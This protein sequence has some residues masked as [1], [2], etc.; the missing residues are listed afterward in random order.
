MNRF[1]IKDVEN[2]SGIKAHTWRIWEQRY[3]LALPQRKES[4][5]RFYDTE[6]LKQ[7][8]RISYLYHQQMK[9]S[10]IAKLEPEEMKRLALTPLLKDQENEYYAKELLEASLDFDE[11][12]FERNIS[13]ALHTFGLED[14]ILKVIYPY[15]ERIGML[16]LTDH[17]VPAQEHFT[18]NL[19]RQ[20]LL[21]AIDNLPA[22]AL[23]NEQQIALF[24]PEDE[25]HEIP[26]LFIYYLL[27]KK[28]CKVIYFGKHVSLEALQS[29]KGSKPLTHALFHLVTNLTNKNADEYV[30]QVADI[31]KDVKVIMSGTQV[32]AVTQTPDNFRLLHS[33]Q[34]IISFTDEFGEGATK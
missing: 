32:L 6:N 9:V 25:Q 24:T 14:T 21:V 4:K 11:E 3:K 22:V 23:G 8:L 26:L 7:V 28:G 34:E 17:V 29:Y 13:I 19:I 10:K 15:Q 16:W 20:K 33:M 1:T 12:R 27:K 31:F 5:H 2:L 30:R 18:S